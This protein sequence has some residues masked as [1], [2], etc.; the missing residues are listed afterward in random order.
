MQTVT[1]GSMKYEEDISRYL[2]VYL[3]EKKSDACRKIREYVTKTE[4]MKEN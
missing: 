3:L 2:E 4:N 1:P